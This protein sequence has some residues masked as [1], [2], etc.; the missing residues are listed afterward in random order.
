LLG[1]RGSDTI[2]D[3]KASEGDMINLSGLLQNVSQTNLISNLGNYL[4]LKQSATSLNDAVITIDV[5]GT[6]TFTGA[7]VSKTITLTNGWV[8]GGLNDTLA[9]LVA[10]KVI[11]LNYQTSTPLVLDLNG[12]GVRTTSVQDG[13]AFDIQGNG[14]VLKT[15]WTDGTDGLL[16]IDLNHDGA[17]NSGAELFGSATV[18]PQGGKA[19]DGFEA[20]RQYD[21]NRDDVIDAQD[22]VFA[23]L[24][25]WTDA[26][27]DG[28]SNSSELLSLTHVGV[29]SINL[30]A[31]QSNALD[32]G[33]ALTLMSNWTS[34]DGRS[35]ALVDVNFTTTNLST[36]ERMVQQADIKVDLSG[37]LGS[38][39]DVRLNDVLA[40]SN[41]TLVITADRSDQ[42]Y[43]DTGWQMTVSTATLNQHTYA[44]WENSQAYLMVDQL[45]TVHT[46]L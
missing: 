30:R 27:S 13:V 9:N 39:Y 1:D 34:I 14:Q 17:I 28:M 41:K 44:L 4:Q 11:N 7:G 10:R 8:S 2:T 24:K 38:R 42:V 32:N 3:F 22:A 35:H 19:L 12:D 15:G 43:L 5:T 25:V 45:A 20:L 36:F 23:D 18:V 33:N 6:S 29:Q 46:V 31:S 16:A 40:T 37:L 26:N 21:T